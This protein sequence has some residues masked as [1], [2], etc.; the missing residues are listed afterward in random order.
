LR[1]GICHFQ[2]ILEGR[3]FSVFTDYKPLV[4]A[5]EWVSDPWTARQCRHLVYLAEF[6][7]DIQYLAGQENMAADTLSRPPAPSISSPSPFAAVVADLRGIASRQLSC[8]STL[9]VS[10]SPS[11]QVSACEVEG[12]TLLCDTSTG[13]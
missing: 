11:L 2:F 1:R 13:R 5:L 8:Q 3:A 9:E 7:S 10:S 12:V 6:T 4:G